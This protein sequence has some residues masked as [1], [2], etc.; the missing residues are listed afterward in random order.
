[1]NT[2]V[3]P[4]YR[5]YCKGVRS[6]ETFSDVRHEAKD[7][8]GEFLFCDEYNNHITDGTIKRDVR[9]TKFCAQVGMRAEAQARAAE[10]ILGH[11]RPLKHA[12][13]AWK[14]ARKQQG[15]DVSAAMD[16]HVPFCAAHEADGAEFA[17]WCERHRLISKGGVDGAKEQNIE[18]MALELAKEVRKFG[19]PQH[20][21]SQVSFQITYQ[22]FCT[23]FEKLKE[24][25][26]EKDVEEFHDIKMADG[27]LEEEEEEAAIHAVDEE[28][29]E[30]GKGDGSK[31]VPK[32]QPTFIDKL[33]DIKE[34]IRAAGGPLNFCRTADSKTKYPKFC[35]K[36]FLREKEKVVKKIREQGM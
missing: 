35:R 23:E 9:K 28:G 2:F 22:K 33:R 11:T 4:A 16:D 12:L 8:G 13:H 32:D 15:V 20:F 17:Q 19:G 21:C 34:S 1:M 30:D 24:H 14:K 29:G 36:V 7:G 5:L 10:D 25:T 6:T 18:L 3:A 31:A 27:E 26:E